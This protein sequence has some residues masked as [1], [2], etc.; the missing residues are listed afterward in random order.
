MDTHKFLF[1]EAK[2][3]WYRIALKKL[4]NTLKAPENVQETASIA[5]P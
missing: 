4:C 3:E 5:T 2:T 1:R